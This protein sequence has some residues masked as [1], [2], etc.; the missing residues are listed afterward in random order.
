MSHELGSASLQDMP[1]SESLRGRLV[2]ASNKL[3]I[4]YDPEINSW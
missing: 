1:G 4:E 3:D 2:S